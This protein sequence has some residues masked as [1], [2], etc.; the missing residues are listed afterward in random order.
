M[1]GRPWSRPQLSARLCVR[2]RARSH[3]LSLSPATSRSERN[4][5]LIGSSRKKNPDR[6]AE[7]GDLEVGEE[8][9][10]EAAGGRQ[11]GWSVCF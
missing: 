11:G 5:P 6:G 9:G 2:I 4:A 7:P 10:M 8:G 1:G 3:T